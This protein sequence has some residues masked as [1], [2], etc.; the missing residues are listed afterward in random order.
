MVASD[1]WTVGRLCSGVLKRDS[2][3]NT[4]TMNI[5]YICAVFHFFSLP[6]QILHHLSDYHFSAAG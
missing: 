4:N 2:L 5:T 3:Q 6:T 1:Q